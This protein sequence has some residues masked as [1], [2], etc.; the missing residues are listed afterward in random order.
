VVLWWGRSLAGSKVIVFSQLI[1][2]DIQLISQLDVLSLNPTIKND[3]FSSSISCWDMAE[4]VSEVNQETSAF[5]EDSFEF[6]GCN[7]WIFGENSSDDMVAGRKSCNELE[8]LVTGSLEQANHSLSL[9][10][11]DSLGW[12]SRNV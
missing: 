1:R 10:E 11:G 3:A 9:G 4:F 5:V 6:L 2:Q 12:P 7:V 8:K